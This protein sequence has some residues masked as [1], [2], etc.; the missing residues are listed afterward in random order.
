MGSWEFSFSFSVVGAP[1]SS[2]ASGALEVND[3]LRELT[4][5]S[6]MSKTASTRL[7][8]PELELETVC[9]YTSLAYDHVRQRYTY[10]RQ[11]IDDGIRFIKSDKQS[12]CWWGF[13]PILL[14][15]F[16]RHVQFDLVEMGFQEHCEALDTHVHS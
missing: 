2:A 10:H 12:R 6:A 1:A 16:F 13:L 7:L 5:D 3:S 14:R 9:R 15:S 8:K 11:Q 4:V